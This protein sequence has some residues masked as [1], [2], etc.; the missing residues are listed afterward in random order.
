ML[1]HSSPGDPG[2]PWVTG[3]L[4]KLQTD[5]S[6]LC[7]QLC[8]RLLAA[9]PPPT[10]GAD[11]RTFLQCA[12]GYFLLLCKTPVQGAPHIHSHW[13]M[14]TQR[15]PV[16]LPQWNPVWRIL[17][18]LNT[19]F[20]YIKCIILHILLNITSCNSFWKCRTHESACCSLKN[21]PPKAKFHVSNI[22]EPVSTLQNRVIHSWGCKPPALWAHQTHTFCCLPVPGDWA[23]ASA[24]VPDF[25]EF[26]SPSEVTQSFCTPFHRAFPYLPSCS[27][28]RLLSTRFPPQP[29]PWERSKTFTRD[30]LGTLRLGEGLAAAFL[31]PV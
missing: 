9:G 25:P 1:E 27:P 12:P 23:L 20:I 13:G 8:P 31:L 19:I 2:T 24:F 16:V 14:L 6:P 22:C 3:L 30:R 28:Q 18:G 17:L 15:K 11:F 29:G 26:L 10:P 4:P 7:M 21:L 5:F